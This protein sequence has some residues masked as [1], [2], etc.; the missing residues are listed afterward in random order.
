[1]DL[2]Q[3][4]QQ[5]GGV[6]ML[7]HQIDRQVPMTGEMSADQIKD[8]TDLSGRLAQSEVALVSQILQL[9]NAN[10]RCRVWP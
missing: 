2:H 4:L 7:A 9:I 6:H 1:M 3:F 5:K 10:H 8:A